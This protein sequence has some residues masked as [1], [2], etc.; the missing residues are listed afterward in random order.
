MVSK[1]FPNGVTSGQQYHIW[2]KPTV[3]LYTNLFQILRKRAKK[4]ALLYMNTCERKTW[5]RVSVKDLR[6]HDH[7]LAGANCS[8]YIYYEISQ[9][10]GTLDETLAPRITCLAQKRN[11]RTNACTYYLYKL[12][13][14]VHITCTALKRHKATPVFYYR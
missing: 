3:T 14:L 5:L 1:G 8:P 4:Y 11:T 13:V 10:C 12:R 7:N 2:E 6:S 9:I